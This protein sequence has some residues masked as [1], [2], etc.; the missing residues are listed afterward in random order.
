VELLP[1]G[2]LVRV[3]GGV[4]PYTWLADGVPVR[5]GLAAREA[6]IALPGPGFITLSVIDA[7][8]RSA[9]SKVRVW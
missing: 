5:V 1:D 9:R 3:R 4:A 8:G 7:T 2:L 6:V